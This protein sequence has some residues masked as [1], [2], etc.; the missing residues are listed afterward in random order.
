MGQTFK[1]A[2]HISWK[3]ISTVP[4]L[5]VTICD[6]ELITIKSWYIYKEQVANERHSPESYLNLGMKPLTISKCEN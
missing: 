3:K 5:I 6:N 2:Y 1:T 4:Y